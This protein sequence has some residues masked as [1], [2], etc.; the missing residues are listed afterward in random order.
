MEQGQL[1]LQMVLS[2]ILRCPVHSGVVPSVGPELFPRGHRTAVECRPW[3]HAMVT[4]RGGALHRSFSHTGL[5]LETRKVA[6]LTC[7]VSTLFGESLSRPRA[8]TPQA[9][10]SG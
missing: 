7:S 5:G 10:T 4:A 1:L 6:S 9:E 2:F 8:Q 3:P